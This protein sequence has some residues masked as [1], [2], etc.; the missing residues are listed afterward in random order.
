MAHAVVSWVWIS[1]VAAGIVELISSPLWTHSGGRN[2]DKTKIIMTTMPLAGDLCK[3]ECISQFWSMGL[4]KMSQ[5]HVCKKIP[6]PAYRYCPLVTSL[7]M[8][9]THGGGQSRENHTLSSCSGSGDKA[10]AFGFS[11]HKEPIL[12]HVACAINT[13]FFHGT[14]VSA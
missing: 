9:P 14:P 13:T 4:N 6:C 3:G 10:G 5:G 8:K 7:R 1:V 2:P 12:Q 11:Q